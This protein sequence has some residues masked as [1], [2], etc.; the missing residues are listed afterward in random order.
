MPWSWCDDYK[1]WTAQEMIRYGIQ[2]VGVVI[3]GIDICVRPSPVMCVAG[4]LAVPGLCRVCAQARKEARGGRPRP[5]RPRT[6]V[7]R[8]PSEDPSEDPSGPRSTGA[9]EAAAHQL[10]CK[11]QLSWRAW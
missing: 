1:C 7:L 2:K 11:H 5:P 10:S 6:R 8:R 4:A 9:Q 3:Y